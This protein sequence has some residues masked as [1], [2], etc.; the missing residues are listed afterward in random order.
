M[1][2]KYNYF[3]IYYYG[4]ILFFL[5]VQSSHLRAQTTEMIQQ[6]LAGQREQISEPTISVPSIDEGS[7]NLRNSDML[8]EGVSLYYPEQSQILLDKTIDPDKY[9][10]GPGDLL[11]IYLWGEIDISYQVRVSPEGYLIIPAV[12]TIV[13]ADKTISEVSELT[14]NV[15]KKNY[16]ELEVTVFLTEPRRFRLNISG[17]VYLPGMHESNALERVSDIIDRAGLIIPRK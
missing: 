12:G 6:G 10:V 9:K 4:L 5:I 7:A 15:I 2:L 1:K 14:K 11:G 16:K 17:L 3:K 13:V 8:P